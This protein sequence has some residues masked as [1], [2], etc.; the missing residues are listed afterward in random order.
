MK[1]C[2][3]YL[4]L[5][6]SFIAKAQYKFVGYIDNESSKGDIYLSIIDDYR[7]ISGVYSEQII[8]E[9]KAD[10]TGFFSFSGPYLYPENKIYRI[11]VDNCIASNQEINHFN[12]HCD[13]SKEIVFIA[14]DADSI[15][16]PLLSDKQMFCNIKS[17]NNISNSFIRIDSLI[18]IMKF[19]YGNYHSPAEKKLNDEKWF[20]QLQKFG[21]QLEEPLA[22]LYIYSFL[23]DRTAPFYN[24]YKKDLNNNSFY[25]NLLDQ[26][27]SNYPNS[28]YTKQYDLE[29]NSD[30]YSMG[31]GDSNFNRF[32]YGTLFL[33]LL[34][35]LMFWWKF[36]LR[37]SSSKKISPKNNL[38]KQ[39]E[40][41][42]Y[43]I[44]DD[45]SNKEIAEET[46]TSVSTVKTHI[47][48]IYKKLN[49]NSRVEA[50]QL[51]K[52]ST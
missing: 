5:L 19:D 23:S 49:L 40:K 27:K 22:E 44:L 15:S 3:C 46:F 8:N 43:L 1:Q 16:F 7:K 50:M 30:K 48:N 14:K 42:L 45:K 6:T 33:S 12:G 47:N 26:L 36:K 39:E 38:T 35:N 32:L 13:D 17:S 51:F 25:T 11:H 41:I 37:K 24:Y 20:T 29:L 28:I 31:S 21:G 52:K 34:I 10:T 4:F 2:L 18:E 9:T